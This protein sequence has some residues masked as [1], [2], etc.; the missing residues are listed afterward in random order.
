MTVSKMV[1]LQP[2]CDKGGPPEVVF[3]IISL[4][5]HDAE[6]YLSGAL[7]GKNIVGFEI[8]LSSF[9]IISDVA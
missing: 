8:K 6:R 4:P 3:I 2:F 9:H 7:L 5:S 1:T